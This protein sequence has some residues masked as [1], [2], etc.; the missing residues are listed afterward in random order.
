[1][2]TA[3]LNVNAVPVAPNV[4]L[5]PQAVTVNEGQGASLRV[6]Y[7]GS[8][9]I[10][11]TLQRFVGGNWVDA[12]STTSAACA[13]PC[14]TNTP[15]LQAEDNGAMY[16][17]RLVNAQGSQVTDAV[18]VTVTMTRLP[19]FTTL[20]AAAAI[21]AGQN[22]SFGFAVGNDTGSFSYQWL[23]NG[24]P[25]VDGSNKPSCRRAA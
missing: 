16:R 6:G 11:L 5:Q 24:Q 9:P 23:A 22:A 3:L 13:S 12:G 21:D 20:P 19:Q 25:L 1:M 7:G 8:L 2:A 10:T 15:V 17:L 4:G 14:T 18:T